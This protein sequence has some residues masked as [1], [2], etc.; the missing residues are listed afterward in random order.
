MKKNVIKFIIYILVL[1]LPIA[2][3]VPIVE[4]I[5]NQYDKTYFAELEDKYQLLIE[6]NEPKI[7]F[8]GGS[9]LPFGLRSDLIEEYTG[10][11]VVN[12]GLYATLGTKLMM[13]LSKA[14]INEGDIIVL[15]PELNAQTYSLYFNPDAVLQ[16]CDG[17]NRMMLNLSFKDNMSLFYNYFGYSFNKI[18]FHNESNA[19]DPVGVYR[20]DSFNKYGDIK[21]ERQYNIM[22]NR[23]DS[24]NVVNM[25]NDLLNDEF[26]EYVNKYIKYINKKKATIVFN[27][28]PYNALAVRTSHNN[29]IAF[30]ELLRGKI[31][32]D[33]LIDIEDAML[34][35]DYFY[36]TNFHLNSNGAICYTNVLIKALCSYLG[37]TYENQIEVPKSPRV[38]DYE[39]VIVDNNN[40]EFENYRGEPNADYVDYFEYAISGSTYQIVGIKNEYKNIEEIILPSTYNGRNVTAVSENALA[41]LHSLKYVYIGK[42]YKL[43]AA[44]IFNG[45]DN[46]RGI[47][48]YEIDGNLIIPDETGLLNGTTQ[49]V[50]I[51]V[52]EGSNYSVGYTW[53]YYANRLK[54]FKV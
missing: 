44:N 54:Y 30:D 47:Y 20:H 10:Y 24:A 39:T 46:L 53:A 16:A 3:Y 34:D 13:D 18:K 19:P 11:K 8:I 48:L 45:C 36:D 4:F 23:H 41:Q 29:R 35:C 31:N 1:V 38:P 15:T 14:N 21:V 26:I 52:P 5:P 7:I 9:S 49:R 27:Y 12:F 25:G 33:F 32:C 51:F 2:I 6:T 40:V 22:N 50:Q 28:S 37:K 43:L 42:T 17:Y